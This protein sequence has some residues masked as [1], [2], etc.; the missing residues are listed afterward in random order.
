[1]GRKILVVTDEALQNSVAEMVAQCLAIDSPDFEFSICSHAG[2]SAVF[3]KEMPNVAIVCDYTTSGSLVK[4]FQSYNEIRALAKSW[5]VVA[6]I[7]PEKHD[8]PDHI[9]YPSGEV[10]MV[11]SEERF[12]SALRCLFAA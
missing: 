10:P 4:G 11:K 2:A 12:R 1:M 9:M 3:E 8:H 6:R 5:Q 7:G